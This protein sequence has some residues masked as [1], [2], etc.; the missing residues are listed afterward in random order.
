MNSTT[1]IK[2]QI[3]G[4]KA[5]GR[6]RLAPPHLAFDCSTQFPKDKKRLILNGKIMKNTKDP[7]PPICIF[8]WWAHSCSSLQCV[9]ICTKQV[10]GQ[11]FKFTLKVN[12]CQALNILR[13]G[14]NGGKYMG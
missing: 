12:Q 7:T 6:K 11:K 9:Y 1:N 5:L 14:H 4:A 8:Y 3:Y 2:R 10:K 13:K